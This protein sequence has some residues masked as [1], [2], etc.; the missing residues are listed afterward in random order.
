MKTVLGTAINTSPTVVF[1]AGAA[2]TD[3][4]AKALAIGS[5]KAVLPT[6]G[7]NVIGIS[8]ME[9]DEAV[10]EGDDIEIQIKDIGKW[11]AAEAI[12]IGD[13]LATDAT[14]K[15]KKAIAG[16]FIVGVA[17]TA[18][19]AAGTLVQVQITKSGYKS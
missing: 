13:E 19:S 7:A 9:T 17:M 16:Q 2:I 8:G 14:G 10:A 15:A 18:A 1:P 11:E 5:G 3:A 6:A 4:R 12:A